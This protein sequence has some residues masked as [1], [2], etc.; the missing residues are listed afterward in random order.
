ML[1]AFL[2]QIIKEHS[3]LYYPLR[4]YFSSNLPIKEIIP[5]FELIFKSKGP[6]S[7]LQKKQ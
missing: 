4:N 7:F 6:N 2:N 5:L 1:V 3:S